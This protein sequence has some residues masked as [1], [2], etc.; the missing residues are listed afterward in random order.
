ME[1]EWLLALADA[2]HVKEKI[3][4]AGPQQ[5]PDPRIMQHPKIE[6]IGPVAMTELPKM[7]AAANVLIMP[8]ADLP[9]TRAMQPLKFK[10]YIATGRPVVTSNLPAV[11][12]LGGTC[13]NSE[14]SS[15]IR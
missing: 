1:A 3:V 4:L 5:D 11:T 12:T 9:V 6:A 2:L 14:F 7:A 8:Y 15:R 13:Q 10:E